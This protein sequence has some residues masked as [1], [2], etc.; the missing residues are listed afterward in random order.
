MDDNFIEANR[1]MW[2]ET[3]NVH[4]RGYVADPFERIRAP[5]FSTFDSVEQEIFDT[6]ELNGKAVAQLS[7]NNSRELISCK[8]AGAG[9]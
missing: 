6:L 9:R 2:N 1:A 5:D 7:C 8:K 4:E 3:A